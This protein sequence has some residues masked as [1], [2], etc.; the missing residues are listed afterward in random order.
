VDPE[1]LGGFCVEIAAEALEVAGD[2]HEIS[3]V[4]LEGS[5]PS[6]GKVAADGAVGGFELI[7]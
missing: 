2:E 4:D 3:V 6:A 7:E 1:L 5:V